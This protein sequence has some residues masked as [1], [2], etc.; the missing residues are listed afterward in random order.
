ML[1]QRWHIVS[2]FGFSSV[3]YKAFFVHIKIATKFQSTPEE[4]F[5]PHRRSCSWNA[6][7]ILSVIQAFLPSFICITMNPSGQFGIQ[8]SLVSWKGTASARRVLL[9]VN[10]C[11]RLL[12]KLFL[13][14]WAFL[15]SI[16]SYQQKHIIARVEQQWHVTHLTNSLYNLKFKQIEHAPWIQL[17]IVCLQ[18]DGVEIVGH[19]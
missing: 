16:K 7:N 18:E 6:W 15:G 19:V 4:S 1:S 13:W 5:L 8:T 12:M 2:L 14:Q 9:H 3:Y 11:F 10:I 17:C